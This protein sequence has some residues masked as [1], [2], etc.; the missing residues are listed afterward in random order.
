MMGETDGIDANLH[1]LIVFDPPLRRASHP[2]HGT[3]VR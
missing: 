1:C 3:G 2:V